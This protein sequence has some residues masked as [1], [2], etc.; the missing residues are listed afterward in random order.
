MSKKNSGYMPRTS[1]VSITVFD[2]E[3][4]P[5]S[6]EVREALIDS[7]FAVADANKL[8]INIATT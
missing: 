7:V 3:G 2:L 1:A 4:R 6:A 5:I 8:V